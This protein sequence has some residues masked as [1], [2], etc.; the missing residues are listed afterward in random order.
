MKQKFG[1]LIILAAVTGLLYRCSSEQTADTN[2]S[3]K[4]E[5]S[6]EDENKEAAVPNA[7]RTIE[8]TVKQQPGK[9]VDKLLADYEGEKNS[10]YDSY[11]EETFQPEMEKTV[12]AYIKD[13]PNASAED[14]YD[15]LVSMLGSGAYKKTSENM[16]G[17]KV[18]FEEPQ[19]PEGED[20]ITSEGKQVQKKQNAVILV[21]ASGSMKGQVTGGEKMALAKEAVAEFAGELSED[22]NVALAVYGHVG[23]NKESDKE[24]SCGKIETVYDLSPFNEGAFQQALLQ[25]EA[26]GWTPLGAGIEH[27]RTLLEPFQNEKYAN[28][29]YIVSDGIE[30][31]GG[32]PAAAAKTLAESNIKAKVNIIGFDVDDE[33]QTQLKQVAEAGGG[34]YATVRSKEELKE[35]I[36][37]KWR[38]SMGTLAWIHT[39][40]VNPWDHLTEMKCFD[41]DYDLFNQVSYRERDR[42]SAAISYLRNEELID[43]EKAEEA[44]KIKDEMYELRRQYSSDLRETKFAEMQAEID[45]I[46][47][48][49]DEWKAQ[50]E[51]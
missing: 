19:F 32:D 21:D 17:F 35:T 11:M 47:Q 14:I 38:P 15:Y 26:T 10:D 9:L 42:L 36:L 29:V 3:R 6:V 25:F 39:E 5:E 4:K 12:A 22:A 46:S 44:S 27:A 31:C 2:N 24:K 23:S 34:E 41:E 45:R 13:H 28:T 50:R 18:Q 49:V 33:G 1:L 40:K 16:T 43:Q 30:T 20:K 37:K 48:K 8:E 7:P 51:Q